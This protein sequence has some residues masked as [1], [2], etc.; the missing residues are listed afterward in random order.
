M[1]ALRVP[2]D[3]DDVSASAGR[4]V[5]RGDPARYLVRVRRV[6]VGARL[7][8]FDPERAI[9][10]DATV[11][12]MD[13]ERAVLS[14]GVLRP[15]SVVPRRA[16]TLVQAVGKGDKLDQVV[17]DATELG[18]TRIVPVIAAR[19]V[20]RRE[21]D[22][23]H[24]RL[25]RIAIEAARQCGRG[26]APRIDPA[27][28]LTEAV[29]RSVDAE[30]RLALILDAGLGIAVA[31]RTA[32]GHRSVAVA[33]GPEGGFDRADREALAAAGFVEV[34]LGPIVLRTETACAAILGAML[35]TD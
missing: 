21:G 35:A 20:A 24:A 7:V 14:L 26:D 13:R 30:V 31:L 17:R 15:A 19:S 8:A 18:A 22:A 5:L 2:I 9:E 4:L 34:T 10:A 29:A 23:A 12:E 25:R 32:A 27:T 3:L 11:V 1:S 6:E 28:P 33:I 16:V